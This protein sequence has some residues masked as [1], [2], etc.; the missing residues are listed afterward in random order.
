[1]TNYRRDYSEGTTLR[2]LN[3][4]RIK[5][6]KIDWRRTIL[7]KIQEIERLEKNFDDIKT[8]SDDSEVCIY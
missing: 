6:A 7:G 4:K 2:G 1:M 8:E 3:T 5:A